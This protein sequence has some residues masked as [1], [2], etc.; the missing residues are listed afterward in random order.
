MDPDATLQEIR[1]LA[2]RIGSGQFEESQAIELATAIEDLDDWL[3][4]QGFLPVSWL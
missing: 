4:N 3:S 1:Q 2:R